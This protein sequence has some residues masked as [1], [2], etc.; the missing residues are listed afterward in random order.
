MKKYTVFFLVGLIAAVLLLIPAVSADL[1]FNLE[2]RNSMTVSQGSTIT[3]T[4]SENPSTGYTWVM[5]TTSGLQ[6]VEDHYTNLENDRFGAEGEHE[7]VYLAVT[8]GSQ[9]VRGEYRRPF[10]EGSA[11]NYLLTVNVIETKSDAGNTYI[12][13]PSTPVPTII[14]TVTITATPA[15]SRASSLTAAEL[16]KRFQSDEKKITLPLIQRPSGWPFII[17]RK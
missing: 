12:N 7:W 11:R 8:P 5:N 2:T 9:E 4:L 10:E 15:P 14:P 1:P 17:L 6:L 3:I 16:I 13:I